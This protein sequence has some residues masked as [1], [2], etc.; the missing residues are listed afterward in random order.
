MNE[1]ISFVDARNIIIPNIILLQLC[2]LF[3]KFILTI[4][5][6][7]GSLIV[8][9]IALTLELVYGD[10]LCMQHMTHL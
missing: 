2:N 4:K 7:S 1:K 5:S 3:I 6:V 10:T 8:I 9:I